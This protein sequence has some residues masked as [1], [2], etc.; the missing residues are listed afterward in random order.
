M[1]FTKI[2]KWI[3]DVSKYIVMA[4]IVVLMLLTVTD[5]ILRRFFSSPILG[6]SE[7]TQMVMTIILLS[8]PFSAMCNSHIKVDIVTSKLSAPAKKACRLVTLFISAVMAG[9]MASSA[10]MAGLDAVEKNTKFITINFAKAPFI[11]LYSFGLFVLVLAIACLFIQEIR[12]G[13][14]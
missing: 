11:F 8:A 14:T 2:V 7:Y 12:G 4:A 6:V 5:V 13:E 3:T 9:I 1:V 10:F